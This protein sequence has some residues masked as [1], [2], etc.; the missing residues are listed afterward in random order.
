M[1]TARDATADDVDEI[2][3]LVTAMFLDLGDAEVRGGWPAL[4]S[5]AL[6]ERLWVDVGAFVVDAP[7]GDQLAAVAVGILE[8]RLPSPRRSSPQIGYI[9]WV[10]TA[11]PWR[12]R[13]F[14][15]AATQALVAWMDVKGAAVIHLHSSADASDL[16]ARLGFIPS[17][18]AMRRG[19]NQPV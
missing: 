14:G 5:A 9:D 12:R 10:A 7:A 18:H 3:R 6:H 17:E 13:G 2:V 15:L 11:A 19:P 1:T 4:A 8:T 16:Y